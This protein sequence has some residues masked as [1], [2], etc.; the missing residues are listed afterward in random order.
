MSEAV[1]ARF[2]DACREQ[3]AA[4]EP[5]AAW[6]RVT[7]LV[8]NVVEC[9]GLRARVG[10]VCRIEPEG[11]AAPVPAEVIGF[12]DGRLLLMPLEPECAVAPG[13]RVCLERAR[14]RVPAGDAVLGRVVDALGRPL[15]GG[16]PLAAAPTVPLTRRP[17]HPLGRPRIDRPLDVGVRAVNAMLTLG[18]G[19]RVG[20]FA[21]SGVGKSTLLGQMARHTDADVNVIA[22][23]GERGRE[24]RD[25]LEGDLAEAR[26]RSVVV[27][28][29]SDEAPLLRVRAALAATAMAEDFRDRGRH[30]LLMMDSVTRFCT[31]QRE[32]GLAAGEAPTT[33]GYTPS[34][35]S[36]LPR[37][38]ERAGTGVSG[39]SITGIYTVLVEA[40]DP[41]EPVGDQSRA[42]LDGHVVLSRELASRGHYPAIDVL[43][44]VSRVMVD[45]VAPE[46]RALAAR[47]RESLATFR[48]A[49][50]LI[51]I[52]AYEDGSD[53]RIDAARRLR[54][55]LEAF[56]RQASD[57]GVGL[58]ESVEALAGA[59]AAGG[60]AGVGGTG[61]APPAEVP[62]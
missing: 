45:V 56:L 21:G 58:C 2:L 4:V 44:S 18:R 20:I 41:N 33:R 59:L 42:I 60:A 1:D 57:S 55:P 17:E 61:G 25:F 9:E 54:D 16:A 28:A 27:V 47:A 7:S 10:S 8:G 26:E 12:R 51:A 62:A 43:Q 24:V 32:V 53:P 49:E 40:D 52:G 11:A 30:V 29:T 48:Q 6:G 50:D 34:V 38:L 37:L 15:D 36:A 46:H 14:G 39:G 5:L 23:V 31:A 22:L 35:W 13:A 19:A 3:L